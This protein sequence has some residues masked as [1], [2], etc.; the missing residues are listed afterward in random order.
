MIKIKKISSNIGY[1]ANTYLI[2]ADN[3][4]AVIDPSADFNSEDLEGT[5]LKY[6]L[7]THAHFDHFLE[8]ESWIKNSSAKVI[9]S[10]KDREALSDSHKNCY[11]L[12]MY[13]DNGYNGDAST[14]KD[15]DT[16][17]LGNEEI[18]VWEVP[19]HTPG[20][21]MFK[22]DNHAFVGDLAFEGG[23]YGRFDLPGGDVRALVNSL[24]KLLKFDDNTMLYPGHGPKT[25][26]KEYRKHLQ[27]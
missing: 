5:E 16:L 4:C 21:L 12:F 19:G 3:Q 24:K 13:K 14:V 10:E 11:A 20:S 27:I 15:G 6:I 1:A 25:S 8:I 23:G 22:V 7:L 26:I 9:V 18:E 2:I 17:S